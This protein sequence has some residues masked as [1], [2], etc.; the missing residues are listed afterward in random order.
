MRLMRPELIIISYEPNIELANKI[1]VLFRHDPRVTIQPFGLSAVPGT[2]DLFV[3]YY[4]QFPY[5]GL[6]SLNKEE[7]RSWL[8]PDALYFFR[9]ENL[10]VR[11]VRC[12]IETLDSQVLSPYFIKIDVQGAEFDVLRGG[13]TTLA[14]HEPVLLIENPERDPR[15]KSLL[16][17]LGYLEFE[18]V[19]GHFLQ[20][21]SQGTNSFFM[22]SARQAELSA[23]NPKLFLLTQRP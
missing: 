15:I 23:R 7:A 18:F 6:A 3:P 4:G 19:H 12:R 17:P 9:P 21:R 10:E 14:T 2:F 16:T 11:C 5:P 22:T 8:S 1:T 13:Q 20:R